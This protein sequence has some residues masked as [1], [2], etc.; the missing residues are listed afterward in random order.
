MQ[1]GN[2]D[3]PN[4]VILIIDDLNDYGPL[5]AYPGVRTQNIDL[6]ATES[7]RFTNSHCTAPICVPSRT[8]LFSGK[9]P[10]STGSYYNQKT[11]WGHPQMAGMESFPETFKRNGYTTFGAGK[12]STRDPVGANGC[13]VG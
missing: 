9:N 4:V 12:L 5:H 1:A 7:I 10:W 11:T 3:R 13:H 8:S 6:L 2:P